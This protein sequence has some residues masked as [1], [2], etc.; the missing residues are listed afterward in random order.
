MLAPYLNLEMI[1]QR[2]KSAVVDIDIH[3]L[4]NLSLFIVTLTAKANGKINSDFPHLVLGVL[5]YSIIPL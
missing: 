2:M 3:H 4:P 5:D 1:S